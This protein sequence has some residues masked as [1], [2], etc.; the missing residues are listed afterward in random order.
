MRQ[1]CV[2]SPWIFNIFFDG[3]VRQVNERAAGR[4]VRLRDGNG[5]GW[6]IKQVLHADDTVLIAETR[7]HLQHIVNEFERS[8][9]SKE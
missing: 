7:D 4:G 6:E 1:E 8:C 2:M 3:V 5:G 9:D